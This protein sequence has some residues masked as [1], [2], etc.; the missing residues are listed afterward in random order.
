MIYYQEFVYIESMIL[1]EYFDHYDLDIL[2]MI[3]YNVDDMLSIDDVEHVQ[4][5]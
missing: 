3:E 5:V 4:Q 2:M 1:V